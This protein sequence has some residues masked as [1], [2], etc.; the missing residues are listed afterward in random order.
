MIFSQWHRLLRKK[1]IRELPIKVETM[2]FWLQV[3]M[4]FH[5]KLPENGGS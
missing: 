5:S 1:K 3:Q 4:L 2:T